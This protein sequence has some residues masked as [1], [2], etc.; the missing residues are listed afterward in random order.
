M[1][2]DAQQAT[3]HRF[4]A[5]AAAEGPRH[6]HA[7]IEARSY[8]EAALEFTEVWHPPA[9]EHGEVT[10]IVLD[11]ATGREQCFTVDLGAGDAEPC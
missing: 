9:D 3:E 2:K 8:E 4:A 6:C 7:A 10:V 11:R 5:Y 1:P